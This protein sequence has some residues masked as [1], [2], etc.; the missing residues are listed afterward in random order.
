MNNMFLTPKRCARRWITCGLSCLFSTALSAQNLIEYFW[1]NDPG[2]GH[3]SM[4][5]V[6]EGECSFQLP[7]DQLPH[8]ANL[9]GIRALSG[10]HASATLL[11]MVFN[12]SSLEEAGRLEYFWDND[13][14]V[15]KATPCPVTFTGDNSTVTFDLPTQSL[16]AGMHMLGLRAGNGAQWSTTHTHL[17]GVAAQG[18][19]VDCVEYFWD[20]DPGLGL[21]TRYPVTEGGSEVTVSFDVLTEGL[22]RG[23]HTLGIRSHS[24]HWSPTLKRTV[25]VGADNNPIQ[26]LEYFW[27]EDPGPGNATPLTFTGGQVA[28]VNEEIPA[29]QDYGSHVLVIRAQ[30]GGVWGSP[31]VQTFCMNAMPDFALPADTVCKGQPVAVR[32]LTTGATDATTFAWDMNG[33]GK[34]DATGGEDFTYTYTRAGVYL[35]TLTVKTVGECETTCT[36]TV[37]VLDITT[38]SVGLTTSATTVYEEDI[39][40]FTASPVNA[41]DHPEFDWMVNGEVVATTGSP[42]WETDQLKDGDKV[43]VR[44]VSSNPCSQVQTAESREITVKVKPIYRTVTLDENSDTPPVTKDTYAN[45]VTTNRTLQPGCWNTLCLPFSLTAEQVAEAGITEVRALAD[46]SLTGDDSYVSFVRVTDG[47]EAGMPYLVRV[48]QP[49]TLAF[50]NVTVVAAQPQPLTAG[51]ATMTGSYCRTSLNGAYYI[52][53]DRFYYADVP[54]ASKGF[55]AAITLT[56]AAG[57]STLAIRLDDATPIGLIARD[58][59]GPVDVYTP[60]GI[61]LRTA[62]KAE[63]A[64]DGLPRGIYI[65]NGKKAVK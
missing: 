14:G 2:V 27:D 41:G 42:T 6:T 56:D 5:K 61:R 46:A 57:V 32:N 35:A 9:L 21:A 12:T 50:T 38:P 43:K 52:S 63:H 60:D 29:P 20:E 34:T 7:T 25:V 54:V 39:V 1:N 64:L 8:G 49:T 28:L 45:E 16:P 58:A 24:T 44:V 3:A 30:A 26:A 40:R 51:Q 17:V 18:G 37:T 59:D 15:G 23:L 19:A 62:V 4:I 13:P 11:K 47:I 53:N 48:E 36:R 33:D 65:V 31:L 10:S 22:S 55:R